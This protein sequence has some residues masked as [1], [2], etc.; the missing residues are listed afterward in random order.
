[1]SFSAPS[2]STPSPLTALNRPTRQR[3][4]SPA[5]Q[6]SLRNSP[7]PSHRMNPSDNIDDSD[8]E[9]G[10]AP[11]L[12]AL[13]R[14]LLDDF[15]ESSG[16]ASARETLAD[17]P[18][19]LPE[20]AASN[21]GHSPR[22]RMDWSH[23]PVADGYKTGQLGSS[24][25]SPDFST[26]RELVTPA[27]GRY[28][29]K[30]FNGTYSAISSSGSLSN[31]S[32]PKQDAENR[33]YGTAYG[34][35][36]RPSAT[37]STVTNT[38]A[39]ASAS[40]IR[41]KRAGRGLLGGL[42]GPPRRGPRRD[43]ERGDEEYH[44]GYI[45]EGVEGRSSPSSTA[46]EELESDAN[47]GSRGYSTNTSE[48][49][50][51]EP[52]MLMSRRSRRSSPVSSAEQARINVYRGSNTPEESSTGGRSSP[53][54][55][56]KRSGSSSSSNSMSRA[57]AI[58]AAAAALP[59]G[60]VVND[61]E[62][63]LPP[64]TFRRPTI[65]NS[66]KR[67]GSSEEKPAP[68]PVPPVKYQMKSLVPSPAKVSPPPKNNVLSTRSSNTPLRP[69]P[70]PPKMSMLEAVT[71]SAGA[72]ATAS[73]QSSRRQRSVVHVNGKPY[74]RLDAIGKGGSSK[75][76]KVMAENFKMLA[77]KKVTF[78]S[79]D[80]EAAIRGYKG[81]IDL[82]RKLSGV[83]RVIRLYDWEVN[84]EK[85]CLTML[86]ECGE[87]DLA[88]VLTLRHGHEDSRMDVSFIRYYWREMLL[89]VQAV[90]DLSIIHSDLKPANFL[91]VQ[92]RLKLI[93]FGIANAIQDDTVN[94]HRESQ[95]GTLN[96]M[97]PEAIVD[98]NATSGKA[99]AS[100]GAPRL[101]KLGAPSDVWSLGCILYQMTYGHG[102]FS[103]L[104]LMYQ[105]INAIPDPNYPIDYP[106]TGIGGVPISKSLI[107]TISACLARN[108]DERP[109]IRQLLSD[110]DPF[111]N[112]DRAKEGL[113]DV[114]MDM[115][116][117]LL[118]NAVDH[119]A[120]KGVPTREMTA[121]WAKDVYGKL[122]RRMAENRR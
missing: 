27:P 10:K 100:V 62:N 87:T 81:E 56:Q 104:S 55:S 103:H 24:R 112:P 46:K 69:A 118:E 121:A 14:M 122:E 58:A 83:D 41:W 97:S 96:Y 33:V 60:V 78:S 82:L 19:L 28:S 71:A 86:M 89:C 59:Q 42:A 74:R 8:D 21:G 67:L 80:G 73:Q 32:E 1:M 84:D 115:L 66:Y 98:I 108:K 101:M 106:D 79:Q 72:S 88:K 119:V 25:M 40:A 114:S 77:M 70:P 120:E 17:A 99:M 39:S 65:N 105:K 94:I 113:V 31:S 61:K 93:D 57:A 68:A 15:P 47:S 64:P 16:A 53:A 109:T 5:L 49:V 52:P 18:P 4:Q 30:V 2:A 26:A 44:D 92:G 13:A 22:D 3:R 116:R 76:Y 7:L 23:S 54:E 38:Q 63:M 35:V 107:N 91:L 90:H 9:G 36:V 85:Q 6:T 29:R 45:G 20:P 50:D 37:G 110:N 34:S 51:M 11:Q 111:L 75:V 43:S 95:V 48:D 102:P 12:S 117:L